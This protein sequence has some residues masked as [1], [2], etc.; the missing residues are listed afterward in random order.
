MKVTF[1]GLELGP[2]SGAIIQPTTFHCQKKKGQQ[3]NPQRLEKN[4]V[5]FKPLLNLQESKG[6]PERELAVGRD[7]LLVVVKNSKLKLE[8]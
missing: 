1:W 3:E 8:Q 2:M 6:S 7:L 5:I 4:N